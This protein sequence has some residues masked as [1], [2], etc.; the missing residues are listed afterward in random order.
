MSFSC[1]NS[2]LLPM[3]PR[4]KSE[5]LTTVYKAL[6]SCPLSLLIFPKLFLP[7]LWVRHGQLTAHPHIMSLYSTFQ[8]ISCW[9]LPCSDHCLVPVTVLSRC[10]V[11]SAWMNFSQYLLLSLSPTTGSIHGRRLNFWVL[12]PLFGMACSPAPILIAPNTRWST[13]WQRMSHGTLTKDRTF[14]HDSYY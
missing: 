14:H 13:W 11:P 12:D 4:T 5:L 8:N 3:P 6:Q 1:L 10:H 9:G 7:S 2:L